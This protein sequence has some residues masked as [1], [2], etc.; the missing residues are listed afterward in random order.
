MAD[1]KRTWGGVVGGGNIPLIDGGSVFVPRSGTNA[2][3]G[4]WIIEGEGVTPDDVTGALLT[5][6]GAA[7]LAW[8]PPKPKAQLSS[9]EVGTSGSPTLGVRF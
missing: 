6:A 1:C 3:T 5:G 9:S 8:P 4:E 2:P 7:L